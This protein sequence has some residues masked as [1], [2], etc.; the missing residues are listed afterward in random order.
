MFLLALTKSDI[1]D[2]F[3][4]YHF[5]EFKVH[6]ARL[7]IV[8]DSFLSKIISEKD[9]LSVVE[10][11]PTACG[12]PEE[13]VLS[14]ATYSKEKETLKI[15]VPFISGRPVYYTLDSK[16][17]FYCSTHVSMLRQA[18][19]R[20]RENM[21]ALPEFFVF[22]HTMPP[23]T[24]YENIWQLTVGSSL[25]VKTRNGKCRIETINEFDPPRENRKPDLIRDFPARIA[26]LLSRS[27]EP[28]RTYKNR[29]AVLLSGGLDSSLLL[30]ICQ[31]LGY[32]VDT[33]YSTGYPFE[34]FERDYALSAADYFGTNHQYHEI[35]V[36]DYLRGLIEAISAAEQPLPH[37][38][39]VLLYLLFKDGLPE[40][41]DIV[42]NGQGADGLS[43]HST[44]LP[45]YQSMKRPIL[46]KLLQLID[47]LPTASH[48]PARV[49][50]AIEF[51]SKTNRPLKDPNSIVW[52]EEAFGSMDWTSEHFNVTKSDIIKNRLGT[53]EQFGERSI[54]DIITIQTFLGF[55]A[56]TLSVWSKLGESQQKILYYP[57]NDSHLVNFFFSIP[58]ATKFKRYK[59]V[60]R[61]VAHHYGLPKFIINRPKLGFNP[62]TTNS[63]VNE[64]IFEPLIP[65]VSKVF[66]EQQIRKVAPSVWRGD[67][68]WTFWNILNYS[69]WKRLWINNE[70][71]EDLL[72]EL[73]A[74]N[75]LVSAR[76]AITSNRLG[77]T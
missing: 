63:L 27:I 41:K 19:A 39:S 76:E 44:A 43:C 58:P 67:K 52:S 23:Q 17:N 7:T 74:N 77:R 56:D 54:Y 20:L 2:R 61:E 62:S 29:L 48:L 21:M 3:A 49:R 24:L 13:I 26:S 68:F 22:C 33:T 18:G 42:L 37:M 36:P 55:N 25:C 8:L 9:G 11:P 60:L 66:D 34:S 6:S 51:Q 47:K 73:T 46:R 28:L 75:K 1:T 30:K 57:F 38:Q 4:S 45:L 15:S 71:K 32:D 31:T 10:S 53:I 50:A 16:G 59:H 40:S 64:K 12:D 69:I 72:E 5:E 35:T 70:P 65:V 14:Q